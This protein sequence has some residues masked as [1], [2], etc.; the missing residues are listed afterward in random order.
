MSRILYVD[1]DEAL[2]FLVSRLMREAGHEVTVCASGPE[3]L[4]AL[5]A[6]PEQFGLIV[7]DMNMPGMS[8]LEFA[9]QALARQPALSIVIVSGC[10]SPQEEGQSRALGVREL[11]LKPNGIQDLVRELTSLL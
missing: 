6:Q 11:L 10:V 2:G 4:Q 7:S 3:A 5:D 9:R 8:G 1:D